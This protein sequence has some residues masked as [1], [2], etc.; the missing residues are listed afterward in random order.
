MNRRPTDTEGLTRRDAVK[1]GL[2]VG[3]GLIGASALAAQEVNAQEQ[4][5]KRVLCVELDLQTARNIANMQQEQPTGDDVL[6]SVVDEF[7]ADDWFGGKEDEIFRGFDLDAFTGRTLGDIELTP[8]IANKVC[9]PCF[10]MD[11]TVYT[12]IHFALCL[13]PEGRFVIR[14]YYL[15]T[16]CP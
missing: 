2:A 1:K 11:N 15:C 10:T 13:T 14:C 8:E 5:E 7:S 16:P 12:R 6:A 3:A 4:S 9:P